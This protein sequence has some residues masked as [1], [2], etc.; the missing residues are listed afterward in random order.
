MGTY[1]NP[2]NAGFQAIRKGR[3]IDKTGMISFLNDTLGTKR[4]LTCISRPRRF[5]KSFAVQMLCA[6]YDKSCDSLELFQDLEIGKYESFRQHLNQYD[7]ICLDITS[8]ISNVRNKKD[9]VVFLQRQVME[10]LHQAY[11]SVVVQEDTNLPMMLSLIHNQL[12]RKFIIIIDE[13][14]ALYREAKNDKKLQ[15]DYM[16]LLRGLFKDITRTDKMIEGAYMTGILP[17]KKYG[18]ESALTDFK[19]YTMINPKNLVKYIGFTEDEVQG[20]CEEF[21]MDFYEIKRWYN[22]YSFRHKQSVYSPNSVMEAVY[23]GEI[24]NY[25]TE[26][27][28]YESLKVYIDLNE[29]G[30]KEAVVQML[31]GACV[32]IDTG[33][34]QND[35]TSIKSRDDVLTLLVHL[36]YLTYH[37]E[38]E[39]VSIP[40][41]EVRREFIRA[42]KAGKHREV[43]KLILS[44]DQLLEDTQKHTC[45]IERYRQ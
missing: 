21:G 26:T 9:T 15:E 6:Y 43:A 7:V 29:D 24:Q 12:G 31:G 10:E 4:K 27:E 16:E 32:K 19:E 36:G 22:G 5:G 34:F 20:L 8:F 17:I 1:L 45:V 42:V 40:N 25:W 13:W 2:G 28:T 18:T 3:Y 37:S 14:D 33:T 39:S 41:E 38:T 11:P 35:M 44:S 23:S 30:L